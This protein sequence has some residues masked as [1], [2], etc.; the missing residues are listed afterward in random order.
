M[1][2]FVVDLHSFHHRHLRQHDYIVENMHKINSTQM[3]YP[4]DR[5]KGRSHEGQFDG[6]GGNT[7]MNLCRSGV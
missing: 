2:S 7:R 6:T 4:S 1:S 5:D 3:K